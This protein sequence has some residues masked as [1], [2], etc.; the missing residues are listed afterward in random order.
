MPHHSGEAGFPFFTFFPVLFFN[1][2][3]IIG[4]D[5]VRIFQP[6]D[7]FIINDLRAYVGCR[8][9]CTQGESVRRGSW[10]VVAGGLTGVDFIP[11]KFCG[12]PS[13]LALGVGALSVST[14]ALIPELKNK[15]GRINT[16]AHS[17]EFRTYRYLP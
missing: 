3:F 9:S 17:I 12:I 5:Y 2:R 8:T 15:R 11:M 14:N 16:T 13:R 4:N 7:L 10:V 1:G 6:G